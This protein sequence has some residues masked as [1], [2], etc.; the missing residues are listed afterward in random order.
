MPAVDYP[1]ELHVQYK[2]KGTVKSVSVVTPDTG[3]QAGLLSASM[4]ANG[5]YSFD[6]NVHQFAIVTV[7]L[8]G[9]NS[10]TIPLKAGW[11]LVSLPL[12]PVNASRA[13]ILKDVEYDRL[14]SYDSGWIEPSEMDNTKGYWIHSISDQNLTVRGELPGNIPVALNEGWNLVGYPYTQENAI[15][16]VYEKLVYQYNGS[17]SSYQPN[18][19]TNSLTMLQPGYGYWVKS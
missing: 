6:V 17:W 11:N 12:Q 5:F 10:Q 8:Q 19:T 3:G 16:D 18:R 2:P 13:E 14:F 1:Q 15:A 9:N 7:E 4:D